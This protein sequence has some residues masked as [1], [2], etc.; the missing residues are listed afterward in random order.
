MHFFTS[1]ITS[2]LTCMSSASKD[3]SGE[4]HKLHNKLQLFLAAQTTLEVVLGTCCGDGWHTVT[5]LGD[6]KALSAVP[7]S[8]LM[9]YNKNRTSHT[10]AS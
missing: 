1:V 7:F 10:Q 9:H 5:Q 4:I 8:L 2:N 6:Y 3:Q